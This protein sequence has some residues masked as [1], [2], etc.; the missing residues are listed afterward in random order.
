MTT[1]DNRV[2]R[3]ASPPRCEHGY[4]C[5]CKECA[6]RDMQIKLKVAPLVDL[7]WANK[8]RNMGDIEHLIF[9]AYRMGMRHNEEEAS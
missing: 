5:N 7:F 9:R 1:E 8:G 6:F 4:Y 3:P 2:V